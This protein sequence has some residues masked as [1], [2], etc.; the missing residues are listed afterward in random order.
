MAGV[1]FHWAK[2]RATC[3]ATE[4]EAKVAAALR[5][6]SGVPEAAVEATELESHYGGS[7]R[8]LEIRLEKSRPVRDLLDRILE[9]PGARES[10]LATV[11][12]RT[13]DDGVLYLRLDK[14]AA[15]QGALR[16][17]DG[18]DCIQVRFRPEVYPPSREGAVLAMRAAVSAS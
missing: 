14:Q 16:L 11:E 1:R 17:L 4:D 6:A 10:L 8:I 18:E 2:L 9:L 15:V 7:V 13:D 5:L 12:R 3:H